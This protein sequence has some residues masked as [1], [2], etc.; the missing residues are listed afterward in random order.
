M[1]ACRPRSS[2]LERVLFDEDNGILVV[3]LNGRRRY[4]Y[5]AVPPALYRALCEADS[6]GR[7]YNEMI[8]GHF[9][10]RRVKA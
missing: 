2:L 10:C 4:A 5:E 1:R 8:K 7:F 6:P 3:S 9:A